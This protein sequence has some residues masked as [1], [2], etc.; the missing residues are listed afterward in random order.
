MA[1]RYSFARVTDDLVDNPVD[2]EAA[3][4]NVKH[5]REYIDHV[6]SEASASKSTTTTSLQAKFPPSA[7]PA[8]SLL[9]NISRHLPKESFHDLVDGYDFDLKFLP[10]RASSSRSSLVD[11]LPIKSEADLVRYARRVASSVGEMVA[12]CTWISSDP[13]EVPW[14]KEEKRWILD[15]ASDMGVA[16]QLINIARDI[17]ADA[18]NGRVYIPLDW[19]PSSDFHTRL[20]DDPSDPSLL[21]ELRTTALRFVGLAWGYYERSR[22]AL[23]KLPMEC[24]NGSKIAIEVY[25]DIGREI[26]RRGGDV[27]TRTV[28]SRWSKIRTVVKILYGI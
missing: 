10:I 11:T 16:L 27:R 26:E 13:S 19:S 28:T 25:L 12:A 9:P 2:A 20:L 3:I 15:R 8:L 7:R 4:E 21:P 5:I 18:R 17:V 1:L 24:R 22:P 14:D 23:D 6:Y